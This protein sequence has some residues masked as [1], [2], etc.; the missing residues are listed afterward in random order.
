MAEMQLDR[1]AA[2]FASAKWN[3]I[4]RGVWPMPI[5]PIGYLK[6]EDRRLKPDPEKAPLVVRAFELRAAGTSWEPIAELLGKG[7]S[8]ATKVIRNRV[9]LG[10]IRQG[11][12]H[13]PKAHPP[14]VSRELGRPLN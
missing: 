8:G 6:G 14:L 7:Q 3:A 11:D 10:E 12:R 2:G 5:V 1:Y 4:A 9:Y 13:N